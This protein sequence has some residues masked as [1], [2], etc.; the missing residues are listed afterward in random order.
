[1]AFVI[2]QNVEITTTVVDLANFVSETILVVHSVIRAKNVKS[3]TNVEMGFVEYCAQN[4]M[5]VNM[6]KYVTFITR[7][8]YVFQDDV[9]SFSRNVSEKA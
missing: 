7:E 8:E 3:D 4:P 6:M 2:F 9:V 1:M 5:N